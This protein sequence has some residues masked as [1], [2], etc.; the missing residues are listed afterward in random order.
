VIR[1]GI[2]SVYPIKAL[3]TTGTQRQ[4]ARSIIAPPYIMTKTDIE[5]RPLVPPSNPYSSGLGGG[6]GE[7]GQQ[8]H[9]LPPHHPLVVLKRSVYMGISLFGLNHL[10]VYNVIVRSPNV[11]HEWFKIGLAATI[12]TQ[13]QQ[14]QRGLAHV[15]YCLVW[16]VPCHLWLPCVVFRIDLIQSFVCVLAP[17]SS[18]LFQF[19]PFC[20]PS[21]SVSGREGLRGNL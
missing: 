20:F 7:G 5:G 18:R 4:Q 21:D 3:S 12:G 15:R 8:Q 2:V 19:C 14:Q 13:Q 10:D 9:R 6:G 11:R 1:Y 17:N 16:R